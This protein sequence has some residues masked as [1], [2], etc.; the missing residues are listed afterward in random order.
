MKRSAPRVSAAVKT[1]VCA[2]VASIG[3]FLAPGSSVELSAQAAGNP[4]PSSA[5][6]IKAG[7]LVFAK[8]CRAC[9]GIQGKGDGTAI[10]PGVK[11]AN[12]V[13]GQWKHGGTDADLFKTIKGGVGPAF[14][15]QAWGDRLSDEEIWNV[16]NY[17]RD[18]SKRVNAKAKAKP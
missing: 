9:H 1:I 17:I 4:I 18:L 5:E 13:A 7:G 3:A 11:P 16:I 12:L 6:S 10:P 15:M 8:N 14:D 2:V